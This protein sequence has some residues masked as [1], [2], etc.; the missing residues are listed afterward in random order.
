MTAHLH[1]QNLA[2]KLFQSEIEPDTGLPLTDKINPTAGNN[3]KKIFS[4]KEKWLSFGVIY[5]LR[6]Q[7]LPND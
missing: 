3:L 4:L 1:F 7:G 5:H 6:V 2:V